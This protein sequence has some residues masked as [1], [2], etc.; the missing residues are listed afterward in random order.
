[1]NIRRCVRASQALAVVLAA[2]GSLATAQQTPAVSP[3][4]TQNWTD[5][6]VIVLSP[7]EVTTTQD[8]G[9]KATNATSGT[10]LNT[11]IKDVPLNLEVIT[12]DFL[13]DTGAKSLREGLR[14]SAGVVLESQSDAFAEDDDNPSSAG[15]NDPRGVT[16]R[17]GESTTKLRGFVI[18]QVL[19]DGFR[20]QYSPT[21]LILVALKCCVDRVRCSMVSAVWAA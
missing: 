9:Y 5:E 20:R 18:D 12:N 10:R 16:R 13:R 21:G 19:R 2:H 11:P 8:K 4:D 3:S 6:E 17:A 7:F 15:A 1:M 14:Y